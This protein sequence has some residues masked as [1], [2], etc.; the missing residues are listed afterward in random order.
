MQKKKK[1][2]AGP[3]IYGMWK[4]ILMKKMKIRLITDTENIAFHFKWKKIHFA[5]NTK[6]KVD[7]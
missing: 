3:N 1:S 2:E 7:L 4:L 6:L 5:N